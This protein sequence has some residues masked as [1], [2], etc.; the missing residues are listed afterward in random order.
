MNEIGIRHNVERGTKNFPKFR[1]TLQPLSSEWSPGPFYKS[2]SGWGMRGE[3]LIGYRR[4]SAQLG[5]PVPQ[6]VHCQICEVLLDNVQIHSPWRWELQRLSKRWKILIP[7]C[8]LILK[9]TSCTHISAVLNPGY[10]VYLLIY[11]LSLFLS[12]CT[13]LLLLSLC[14]S[15]F[16]IRITFLSALHSFS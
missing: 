11:K 2:R 1:Q 7:P 13:P 10:R 12:H 9:V 3:G 8:E 14:H 4:T 16:F 6:C 5:S 15:Y